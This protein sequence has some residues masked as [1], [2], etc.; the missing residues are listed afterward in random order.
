MDIGSVLIGMALLI[1]VAFF[2]L[3]PFLEQRALREKRVTEVEALN[4]E[5]EALLIALR[6][7]DFDHATG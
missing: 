1:G 5:R 3:Q 4:A 2:V 6:D 7:L